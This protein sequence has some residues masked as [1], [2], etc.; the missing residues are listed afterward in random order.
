MEIQELRDKACELLK[1][2]KEVS[3]TDDQLYQMLKKK[4]ASYHPDKMPDDILKE[5]YDKKFIEID[6]LFKDFA[7][8]KVNEHQLAEV[9]LLPNDKFEYFQTEQENIRLEE[10]IKHL[11]KENQ[12]KEQ[13]ILDLNNSIKIVSRESLLKERESLINAIKPKKKGYFT[14]LG[15]VGVLTLGLNVLTKFGDIS[16]V[17]NKSFS[18]NA[19]FVLLSTFAV[20]CILFFYNLIR[21]YLINS[22]SLSLCTLQSAVSFKKEQEEIELHEKEQYA[23]QDFEYYRYEEDQEHDFNKIYNVDS[24]P[25]YYYR[26]FYRDFFTK[27]YEKCRYF[28]KKKSGDF[29]ESDVFFHIKRKIKFGENSF[30]FYSRLSFLHSLKITLRLMYVK[31]FNICNDTTLE[32]FKNIFIL[33]LLNKNVIRFGAAS[34]FEQQYIIIRQHLEKTENGEVYLK[35]D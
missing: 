28:D 32:R 22:M 16:S 12:D 7:K 18:V 11:E 31:F 17:L 23:N 33:E 26:I 25:K 4:R 2:E 30:G 9:A 3:F 24:D 20:I 14:T 34:E 15:V 29:S 6:E 21:E 10:A 19:N 1:I 8:T 5:D 13:I 27:K 35:E